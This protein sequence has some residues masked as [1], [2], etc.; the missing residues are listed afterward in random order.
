MSPA[1]LRILRLSPAT[2]SPITEHAR[3]PSLELR[4]PGKRRFKSSN[5]ELTWD[6]QALNSEPSPD[7]PRNTLLKL[8]QPWTVSARHSLHIAMNLETPALD[9]SS[10]LGFAP[11]AFF[12]PAQGWA[13]QLLPAEGIFAT[14]GAPPDKWNL[15]LHVPKGFVVHTSGD[16]IKTS[17]HG[18]ETAIQARQRIVDIYPYVIAGRY[19]T[20]QIGS[21]RQKFIYGLANHRIPAIFAQSAIL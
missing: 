18:E 8:P 1:R 14:G 12:L 16:K 19:V 11:D 3:F 2:N 20:K 13:P 21:D 7:F 17:Q 4:L 5:I 10:Y 6:G 15:T 9:E